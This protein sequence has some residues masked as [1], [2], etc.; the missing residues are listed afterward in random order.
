MSSFVK[1]S[2]QK[3]VDRKGFWS[4]CTSGQ[5]QMVWL[6]SRRWADWMR[7]FSESSGL[8]DHPSS[9]P[10]LFAGPEELLFSLYGYYEAE[11][12]VERLCQH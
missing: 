10:H 1:I 3:W 12:L 9:A 5:P 2:E 8:T 4:A 6:R 11:N 7:E